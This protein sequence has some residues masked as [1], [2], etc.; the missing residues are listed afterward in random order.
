MWIAD[1]KRLI[2]LEGRDIKL[3][4]KDIV[5]EGK[6]IEILRHPSPQAASVVFQTIVKR[7]SEKGEVI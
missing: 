4:C 5:F 3:E 6:N 7:L 1:G 2:C